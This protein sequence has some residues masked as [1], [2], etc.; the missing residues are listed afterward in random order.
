MKTFFDATITINIEKNNT[1]YLDI[2]DLIVMT[3]EISFY[4]SSNF[5]HQTID[6]E[7]ADSNFF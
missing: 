6:A 3:H 1:R 5:N 4:V 2:V 7:T